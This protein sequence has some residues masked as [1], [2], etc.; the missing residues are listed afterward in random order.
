LYERSGGGGERVCGEHREM[1]DSKRVRVPI[2][3][4]NFVPQN[5]KIENVSHEYIE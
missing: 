4:P 3:S 5:P 2:Y 1:R